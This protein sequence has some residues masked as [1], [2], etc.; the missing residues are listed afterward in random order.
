MSSENRIKRLF[1]LDSDASDARA[2]VINLELSL[3]TVVAKTAFAEHPM[4]QLPRDT[5][6]KRSATCS[7]CREI[8]HN[9][10]RIV[11]LFC[12]LAR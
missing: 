7:G 5:F 9:L 11:R 6:G 12:N 1:R 2:A 4:F 8:R 3:A 10:V